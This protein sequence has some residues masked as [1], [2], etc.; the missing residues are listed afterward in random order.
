MSCNL[1]AFYIKIFLHQLLVPNSTHTSLVQV[2]VWRLTGAKASPEPMLTYCQLDHKEHISMAF[3]WEIQNFSFK[4]MDL[5]CRLHD[6]QPF[7]LTVMCLTS[8]SL[9]SVSIYQICLHTSKLPTYQYWFKLWLAVGRQNQRYP[10]SMRSL[11]YNIFWNLI[12]FTVVVIFFPSN[13]WK[14]HIKHGEIIIWFR[15][16]LSYLGLTQ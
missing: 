9:G 3:S 1:G 7:C 15:I 8:R 12:L 5:K 16:Y 14:L 10:S 13:G 2:M 6:E 11:A 4:K